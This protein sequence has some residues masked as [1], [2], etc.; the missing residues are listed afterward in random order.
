MRHLLIWLCTTGAA[1]GFLSQADA[2]TAAPLAFTFDLYAPCNG[3]ACAGA[4]PTDQALQLQ[5]ASFKYEA[6]GGGAYLTTLAGLNTPLVCDEVSAGGSGAV[7]MTRFAPGFTNPGAGLLEYNAGGATVVDFGLLD[8]DGSNPAGVA[9]TYSQYSA[10]QVLC[11]GVNPVTGGPSAYASGPSYEI[12]HASFED[13]WASEPWVSVQTIN[14]PNA[15]TPSAPS[16][17]SSLKSVTPSSP[18][19]SNTMAYVVQV[20]NA[21]SAANWRVSLGYDHTFFNDGIVAKPWACVLGSAIPQPGSTTGTCATVS[22][23]YTLQASDVQTATDSIYIYVDYT[24]SS[25]ATSGWSTLSGALYPAVAAVFPPYG[26]YPQRFDDKVAVASGNNPVTLNIGS[27]ACANDKTS[28]SCMI[29]TPD[30]KAV[31]SAVNYHNSIN[32]SGL[33][34]LDPLAYF[35]GPYSGSTLPSTTDTLGQGNI[36]AVSCSDPNGILA[37]PLAL[38]SFNTSTGA[39]GALQ[40]AFNFKPAGSLYVP[41]TATCQFTIASPTH[42]PALSV[43][44]SFTIT[45]LPATVTHFAV[46]APAS[47]TAGAAFSSLTVTA[48]DGANNVVTSYGGHVHFTSTDGLSMLPADSVLAGGTGTFN[49]TLK[50][51]GG[52]TISASD[53]VTGSITGTSGTVSVAPAAASR[54]S[55]VA[56]SYSVTHGTP[57]T[58]TVYAYDPYNNI[59][60]NY[61]G[62]VHITSTDGQASLPADS[63]LTNGSGNFSVT[64]NTVGNTAT[65]TATDTV[66]ATVA[67]TSAAFTVN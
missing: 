10:P 12:F 39:T 9:M 52:Q 57:F 21:S 16:P 67:G 1:C 31:P 28:T 35:V 5:A 8:Y 6:L 58:A 45:M 49:A 63:A 11:Y 55:V 2:Q 34:N 24:G 44:Q 22:L 56:A 54:L 14:S 20:H 33:V 29:Y 17:A 37:S 32:S 46:T 7:G 25:A 13:H 42:A 43:K 62:T 18:T 64:L 40:V 60:T 23:P 4:H 66:T 36:G 53:S 51:S 38:G 3:S 27:I 59:A 65:I 26:T 15:G 19:P 48:L 50:T 30:G 47:A 41:G 61:A